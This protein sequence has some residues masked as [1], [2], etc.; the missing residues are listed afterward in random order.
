MLM[1]YYGERSVPWRKIILNWPKILV[2]QV[3]SRSANDFV[4]G[5]CTS[6]TF[7]NAPK[8]EDAIVDWEQ[9]AANYILGEYA[10]F[11]S[12]E[13]AREA[14]HMEI[15]LETAMEGNRFFD[16]RRW[17]ILDQVIPTYIAKD[18]QF[19]TFMQGAV[20]NAD[21]NDYWP[22]PQ[23]QVDVQAGILVQDPAW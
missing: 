8:A 6:Y 18:S 20:F 12:K 11:P 3:R 5:K 2:N 14:V 16:L 21:K 13:Y 22:L 7:P 23:D 10:S 4:M 15:R 17:G 1:C 19:R 9:P